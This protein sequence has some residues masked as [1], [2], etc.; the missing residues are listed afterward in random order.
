MEFVW[1]VGSCRCGCF[2][3]LLAWLRI[4]ALAREPCTEARNTND[5]AGESKGTGRS[6]VGE[7]FA[8]AGNESHGVERY[9]GGSWGVRQT[10]LRSVGTCN[11]DD[12]RTSN[13]TRR[14]GISTVVYRG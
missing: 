5:A 13:T 6:R 11:G 1:I 7:D 10:C 8:K 14:E 12:E 3:C 4:P 9:G 2:V